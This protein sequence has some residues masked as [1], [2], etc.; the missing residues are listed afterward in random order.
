M[1]SSTSRPNFTPGKDPVPTLQEAGWAPGPVWTGGKSLPHRDSI[2][3][4][5]ARSSVAVLTE[6]P[7]PPYLNIGKK[8]VKC[9][10]LG[11]VLYGAEGTSAAR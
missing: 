8:I 1:F 7:G 6:L 3:D 11:I 2:P 5:S 10:I 9:C 4:H